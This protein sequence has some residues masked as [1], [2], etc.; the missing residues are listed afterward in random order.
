M[1]KLQEY[2]E[3]NLLLKKKKSNPNPKDSK[4]WKIPKQ[5]MK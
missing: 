4:E 3:M 1:K 2:N 5:E